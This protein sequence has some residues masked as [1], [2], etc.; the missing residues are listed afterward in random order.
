MRVKKRVRYRHVSTPVKN[1]LFN[2]LQYRSLCNAIIRTGECISKP[3]I[4][5]F[6]L[7]AEKVKVIPTAVSPPKKS[8]S[9]EKAKEALREELGLGNE[10]KFIG[11]ISV[12][13][14]WKG[15]PFLFESF[16]LLASDNPTLHLV[17]VGDGP[18]M[19][20]L[21]KRRDLSEFGN[22]IHLVGHKSNVF[23]YIKAFECVILSS[24][25]NEGIPQC[26]LQAMAMAVPV[27]G[28]R[29]GGIP[30]IITDGKTGLLVNP[31]D[32]I[33]MERKIRILLNDKSA[34]EH[35]AAN[36]RRLVSAEF[37]WEILGNKTLELFY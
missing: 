8:L 25:K 31:E 14:G 11:Q 20:A 33:S 35:L 9:Y 24:I 16:N 21:M 37:R 3:L 28:T 4:K 36:A 26:L 7:A 29:V 13:R 15:H 30:E 2:R 12:L 18:M 19:P 10:S 17:I 27:I 22:R 23:D 6:D 5:A 32:S 1:H 34:R